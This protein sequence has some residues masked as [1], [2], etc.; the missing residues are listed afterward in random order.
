METLSAGNFAEFFIMVVSKNL[1][2]VECY[3]RIVSVPWITSFKTKTCD[4]N[5]SAQVK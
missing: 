1:D 2:F 3:Q 4:L 5:F